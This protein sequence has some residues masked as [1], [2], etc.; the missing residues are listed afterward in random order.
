MRRMPTF[1]EEIPTLAE[2]ERRHIL[3]TLTRCR[4][5]RT[6]AAKLLGMSIRC[7]RIKLRQYQCSDLVTNARQP[8]NEG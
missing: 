7:L 3:E 8:L 4:Y 6:H 5:N 2:I 1:A